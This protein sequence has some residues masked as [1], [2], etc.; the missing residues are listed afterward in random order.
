MVDRRAQ[1]LLD[2]AEDKIREISGPD[3]TLARDDAGLK[4]KDLPAGKEESSEVA[5]LKRLLTGLT[6][7]KAFLADDAAVSGL[8]FGRPIRVALTDDSGYLLY[9][10][11][12]EDTHYL[13]VEA[14]FDMSKLEGITIGADDS[15]EQLKANSALLTRR[16]EVNAFNDFHGSWVYELSSFTGKKFQLKLADLIKAPPKDE[17]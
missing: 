14:T 8:T 7:D 11:V 13:K 4:L 15:E 12:H 3:Y 10:T 6:F 2:V 16:D 9:H 17:N 1:D 5:G